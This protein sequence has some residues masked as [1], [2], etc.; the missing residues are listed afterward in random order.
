MGVFTSQ[1]YPRLR[2]RPCPG[3]FGNHPVNDHR[4]RLRR[5]LP[6]PNPQPLHASHPPHKRRTLRRLRPH[7]RLG[8]SARNRTLHLQP[9]PKPPRCRPSPL[10]QP[11]PHR[12]HR[13]HPLPPPPRPLHPTTPQTQ[14]A[15]HRLPH[16]NRTTVP[17]RHPRPRA[18]TL[19]LGL[20]T[21]RE[22]RPT[23]RG[24]RP[25]AK[26]LGPRRQTRRAGEDAD[27]SPRPRRRSGSGPRPSDPRSDI[28]GGNFSLSWGW[29][30]RRHRCVCAAACFSRNTFCWQRR[31]RRVVG[32]VN[33]IYFSPIVAI[34]DLHPSPPP[35]FF[36]LSLSR[37]RYIF[38]SLLPLPPLIKHVH[39]H[40]Y[41][42]VGRTIWR[43]GGG[44]V[45]K[46]YISNR[47]LKRSAAAQVPSFVSY[48]FIH[49][50]Y[51][52]TH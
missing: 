6:N 50:Q 11:P 45:Y 2:R 14:H 29:R 52:C 39:K 40:L 27:R 35:P 22:R 21:R 4:R 3:S 19:L 15:P 38:E 23:R 10:Q 33:P 16:R 9:A 26:R 48:L 42:F 41:F 47:Q 34:R 8:R 24:R 32:G 13:R 5:R 7:K 44:G 51:V 28:A 30:W 49:L 12:H 17:P 20:R 25:G 46:L 31:R 43:D 36:P 1:T 18:Q 37:E